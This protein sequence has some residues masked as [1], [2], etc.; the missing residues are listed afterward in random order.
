MAFRSYG[1]DWKDHRYDKS[2]EFGGYAYS[3]AKLE[4]ETWRDRLIEQLDEIGLKTDWVNDGGGYRIR[5]NYD[6]VWQARERLM[7]GPSL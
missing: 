4:T 5:A 3:R 2:G 1:I 7:G 6:T